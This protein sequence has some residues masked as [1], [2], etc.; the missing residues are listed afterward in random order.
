LPGTTNNHINNNRRKNM[1]EDQPSPRSSFT[2]FAVGALIGA[3]IA[4]LYA[5]RSGKETRKL[6]AKKAKAL[7]E[8]AQDTVES[9]QEFIHDRKT[10][11]AA[12]IDSGKEA[13]DH[14]KHKRS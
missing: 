11:M 4:L 12:V 7:K 10:D 14:A 8:R 2:I 5:P 9:A 6:L 3:G 1:S 13:V